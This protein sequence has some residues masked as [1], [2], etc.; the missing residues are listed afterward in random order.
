VKGEGV[1]VNLFVGIGC[2][3]ALSPE[4]ERFPKRPPDTNPPI[5]V[6]CALALSPEPEG[7]TKRLSEANL[8]IGVTVGCTP[9]RVGL[10][11]AAVDRGVAI[12]AG[13]EVVEGT[14]EDGDEDEGTAGSVTG[15]KSGGRPCAARALGSD[16][17]GGLDGGGRPVAR[18][19]F[20]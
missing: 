13:D 14:V 6:V 12:A 2:T 8:P 3:P 18:Y 1:D 7:F 20:R 9:G 19:D 10:G 17:Y 4:L 16:G 15:M 11:I 5:G